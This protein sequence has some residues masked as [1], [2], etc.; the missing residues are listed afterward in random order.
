MDDTPEP[1][2]ADDPSESMTFVS[3]RPSSRLARYTDRIGV[4]LFV[5]L[6]GL[7]LA[8]V[9]IRFVTAPYLGWNV[10]WTGEAAQFVLVY[11][12]MVGSIIAARDDDHIRVE[13]LLNQF[14]GRAETV[15]RVLI[16]VLS[17]GFLLFATNG[18]YLTMLDNV[19]VTPGAVPVITLE[20]VYAALVVGFA[21]MTLYELRRLVGQFGIGGGS[22]G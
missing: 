19:G 12:T 2:S 17:V 9:I 14:A 8:Q 5:L 15:I 10:A 3:E 16:G 4:G 13:L 20:V 6:L 1:E 11:M 22:D 21:V 18:A 7:A